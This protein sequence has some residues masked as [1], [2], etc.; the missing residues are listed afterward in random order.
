MDTPTMNRLRMEFML[1]NCK[2]E[3]PTAAAATEKSEQRLREN[4]KLTRPSIKVHIVLVA[5]PTN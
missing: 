3:S 4:N 1:V 5:E 2:K